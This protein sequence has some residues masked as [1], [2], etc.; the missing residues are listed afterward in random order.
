MDFTQNDIS[1]KPVPGAGHAPDA[2]VTSSK[3]NPIPIAADPDGNR[4]IVQSDPTDLFSAKKDPNANLQPETFDYQKNN[5][6]E[7]VGTKNYKSLGYDPDLG[8]VNELKYHQ[9]QTALDVVGD[10]IKGFGYGIGHGFADL[11]MGWK[12]TASLLTGGG[13][14]GAFKEDEIA[15][16]Q[17]KQQQREN[18]Y[19]IY[20][21]PTDHS[22]VS[23]DGIAKGIQ[24]AGGIVG[25][26]AEIV[27]EQVALS[28]ITAATLG[29]AAPLQ[30]IAAGKDA[31]VLGELVVES[32][33]LVNTLDKTAN[34]RNAYGAFKESQQYG[35][36]VEQAKSALG[37]GSAAI[38][39]GADAVGDIFSSIGRGAIPGGNTLAAIPDIAR[40]AKAGD[41][42]AAVGRG[43][44]AFYNDVRD[45]NLAVSMGQGSAAST[46]QE[47]LKVQTDNYKQDN[48]I[49]PTGTDL[50]QIQDKAYQAAKTSGAFNALAAFYLNKLA[51]G[52]MLTGSKVAQEAILSNASGEF[53]N[54]IRTTSAKEFAATGEKLAMKDITWDTF[55]ARAM[56]AIDPRRLAEHAPSMLGHGLGFGLINSSQ[57]AINDAVSAYY[58]AKYSNKAISATD[59]IQQGIDKQFTKEGARSFISGVI[60]GAIVSPLME[61]GTGA[62]VRTVQK[63]GGKVSEPIAPAPLPEN[64]TAEQ[65]TAYTKDQQRYKAQ[66]T[67]YQQRTDPTPGKKATDDEKA[68]YAAAQEHI[69]N[70]TV[71]DDQKVADKKQHIEDYTD[72]QLRK[73]NAAQQ[74]VDQVNAMWKNPLPGIGDV[75]LQA[76]WSDKITGGLSANDKKGTEDAQSDATINLLISAAQNGMIKPYLNHLDDK[77]SQLSPQEQWDAIYANVPPS[78]KPQFTEQGHAELMQKVQ[79]FKNR[80][81]DVGKVWSNLLKQFPP[82]INP[83]S[84]PLGSEQREAAQKLYDQHQRALG[85]IAYYKASVIDKAERQNKI[86]NGDSVSGG[87][88][89]HLHNMPFFNV[90]SFASVPDMTEQLELIK[91]LTAS[92]K[93][94]GNNKAYEYAAKM[95]K[96]LRTYRDMVQEYI[97]GYNR[98]LADDKL[99]DEDRTQQTKDHNDNYHDIL[100]PLL[101]ELINNKLLDLDPTGRNQIK[102]RDVL[103]KV[104]KGYMDYHL[105]TAEHDNMLSTVNKVLDPN[106]K[107]DYFR[108]FI[109]AENNTMMWEAYKAAKDKPTPPPTGPIDITPKPTDQPVPTDVVPEPPKPE[110]PKPTTFDL[111]TLKSE[112]LVHVDNMFGLHDANEGEHTDNTH[113]AELERYMQTPEGKDLNAKMQAVHA[114]VDN[115]GIDQDQKQEM[116]HNEMTH[117]I[118][119]HFDHTQEMQS[120]PNIVG[121]PHVISNTDKDFRIVTNGKQGDTVYPTSGMANRALQTYLDK[122]HPPV[123][124]GDQT[125]R[126]GQHLYDDNGK[127]HLLYQSKGKPYIDKQPATPE[128]LEQYHIDKPTV[129]EP[130]TSAKTYQKIT[131][132]YNEIEIYA[133]KR[134][135]ESAEQADARLSD[136]L[137]TTPDIS[138]NLTVTLSSGPKA[139]KFRTVG[140]DDKI[141]P[142]VDQHNEPITAMV[143]LNGT[144]IGFSNT[145]LYRIKDDK[146]KPI[147]TQNLTEAD[148]KKVYDTHNGNVTDSLRQFKENNLKARTILADMQQF[149]KGKIGPITVPIS[150]FANI[151]PSAGSYDFLNGPDAVNRPLV[152]GLIDNGNKVLKVKNIRTAENIYG[153][154]NAPDAEVSEWQGIGTIVATIQQPNG[155][156]RVAQLQSPRFK[157]IELAA[158][159]TQLSNHFQQLIDI[160]KRDGNS[161]EFKKL[162]KETNKL[163]DSIFYAGTPHTGRMILSTQVG[164]VKQGKPNEQVAIQ[165]VIFFRDTPPLK[166]MSE[167]S[168][169]TLNDL[170]NSKDWTPES[171]AKGIQD[172]INRY[173][174]DKVKW[175]EASVIVT[176]DSMRKDF[177]ENISEEQLMQ[178][179][180]GVSVNITKDHYLSY[181]PKAS[182]VPQEIVP[183]SDVEPEIKPMIDLRPGQPVTDIEAKRA[184]IEKRKEEVERISKLPFV[185]RIPALIKAG[186]I[187]SNITYNLGNRFPIIIN[188][189][190]VKVAFY[191]SSEG[192]GGKQK[193]AWTPMFGF[194]EDGGNPWLIKGDIDTQVN[195]N[196]SSSAIKEY[197]DILNKTLNWDHNLDKGQVN[198]HP[199]FKVLTLA[200]SKEDFNKELYGIG[201]LGIVNRETNV[202]GYINSKL[203]EINAKYDA[204]LKALEQ[205]PGINPTI[206]PKPDKTLLD[207]INEGDISAGFDHLLDMDDYADKVGDKVIDGSPLNE[208]QAIDNDQFR[209]ELKQWIPEGLIDV[210]EMDEVLGRM[211]EQGTTIGQ[212]VTHINNL[213]NPQGSIHL[214]RNAPKTTGYHEAGHGILRLLVPEKGV[215]QLLRESKRQNPITQERIDNFLKERPRFIGADKKVIEDRVA[216]EHIMDTFENW[217]KDHK[218]T[219]SQG[220]KNFFARLWDWIKAVWNRIKGDRLEAFFYDINRGAYKEAKLADNRF[221]NA[222]MT[223]PAAKVIEIGTQVIQDATGKDIAIPRTLDADTSNQITSAIAALY[224]QHVQ[225]EPFSPREVVLNRIL[226]MY[227]GML[228]PKQEKYIDKVNEILNPVQKEQFMK[229]L[230]NRYQ[231]FNR[232]DSRQSVIDSVNENLRLL[233][234]QD[235][236]TQEHYEELINADIREQKGYDVAADQIGG[237]ENM[238]KAVKLHISSTTFPYVDEFGNTELSDGIPLVQG[239]NAGM[240]YNGLLQTLEGCTSDTAL[241]KRLQAYRGSKSNPDTTAYINRLLLE[242]G[243]SD[244]GTGTWTVTKNQGLFQSVLNTFRQYA[245]NPLFAEVSPSQG[246]SR[247]IPANQQ[248]AAKTQFSI[249]AQAHNAVYMPGLNNLKTKVQ[250]SDYAKGV[251]TKTLYPIKE[252]IATKKAQGTQI[253]DDVLEDFSQH[254]SN[255]IKDLIGMSLSPDLI[256]YSI[257]SGKDGEVLTDNQKQLINAYRGKPA[258]T[259]EQIDGVR[260][261][262]LAGDNIFTTGEDES[263]AANRLMAWFRA[264]IPFDQSAWSMS[265]VDPEGKTRWG[266]QKP[267]YNREAVQKLNDSDQ[268]AKL[269]NTPDRQSSYLLSDPNFLAL[270]DKQLLKVYDLSGI[271]Q[272]YHAMVDGEEGVEVFA[273]RNLETNQT[274]G[275]SFKNLSQRD[276]T[277]FAITSYGSPTKVQNGPDKDDYFYTTSVSVG[278]IAESST[279]NGVNLPVIHAVETNKAGEVNLSQQAV[280]IEVQRVLNDIA[281][282]DRTQNEIATLPETEQAIDYHNG[283]LRGIRLVD[284]RDM[285][286]PLADSIEQGIQ[287][288]ADYEPNIPAIEKQI[289]SYWK[290]KLNDFRDYLIDQKLIRKQGNDLVNNLLPDFISKGFVTKKGVSVEGKNDK[291]NLVAGNIRHNLAQVYMNNTLN[292]H[293]IRQV[294]YGDNSIAFK[295]TI[296]SVRKMKGVNGAGESMGFSVTAPDLGINHPLPV[297]HHALIPTSDYTAPTGEVKDEADGLMY[298]TAKGL[299]YALFGFGELTRTQADILDAI[300]KGSPKAEQMFVEAGG[301]K[302]HIEAFNSKKVVY[303]DGQTHLKC[304]AM[305]LTKQFTSVKVG[306]KWQ[307]RLGRENLHHIR[308]SMEAFEKDMDLKGTPTIA[309]TSTE[310]SSKGLKRTVAPSVQNIHSDYFHEL[311][312]DNMRQQVKLMSNK[313]QI[314]DPNGLKFNVLTEQDPTAHSHWLNKPIGDVMKDYLKDTAQRGT[315]SY[316]TI[317]NSMFRTKSGKPIHIDDKLHPSDIIPDFG[318]VTDQMRSIQEATGADSQTLELLT[319]R[320]GEQVYNWNLSPVVAK[321]TQMYLSYM[322]SGPLKEKVPGMD[323]VLASGYGIQVVREIHTLDDNGQPKTWTVHTAAMQ[324]SNGSEEY[325][326]IHRHDN[327]TNK[328][329]LNLPDPTKNKVYV[330]DNLKDVY[331]KFDKEGKLLGYF[332][333][334]I[335]PAHFTDEVHGHVVSTLKEAV[336]SRIPWDDKHQAVVLEYVDITPAYMGSTVFMPGMVNFRS[337]SDDD[338]DTVKVQTMDTYL[339]SGRRVS[340]GTATTEQGM[341]HEFTNW[342]LSGKNNPMCKRVYTDKLNADSAYKKAQTDLRAVGDIVKTIKTKLETREQIEEN[343]ALQHSIS[344]LVDVIFGETEEVDDFV[345]TMEDAYKK[346]S[347]WDKI[348]QYR[349]VLDGKQW[350]EEFKRLKTLTK[351]ISSMYLT[352]TLREL[353]MPSTI[354]EFMSAG[355]EDINNGVLNNRI[356]NQKVALLSNEHIS[357]GGKDAIINQATD[358]SPVKD[359]LDEKNSNSLIAILRDKG[360]KDDAPIMKQLLGKNHDITTIDGAAQM[361]DMAA[362]GKNDVG[363][364]II[365][366]MTGGLL[367]QYD[368]HGEG[369]MFDGKPHNSFGDTHTSAG[370]RKLSDTSALANTMTDNL[371]DGGTAA[372][373][374]LTIDS[375]G[376]IGAMIMQGIPL[377]SAMWYMVQ[378]AVQDYFRELKDMDSTIRTAEE[379]TRS[380]A[381]LLDDMIEKVGKQA[382]AQNPGMEAAKVFGLDLTRD[383]L[384]DNVVQDGKDARIQYATLRDIATIKRETEAMGSINRIMSLSKGFPATWEDFDG[385]EDALNKLGIEWSEQAGRYIPI[386]DEAFAKS[387][388]P[389]DVR[390]VLTS[391]HDIYANYLK[392]LG[393]Q[394]QLS[395]KV[396]LERTDMFKRVHSIITGNLDIDPRYRDD[397]NKMAKNDFI[398]YL[399]IL[400]NIHDLKSSGGYT[401]TLS[402]GLIYQAAQKPGEENIT[403][404]VGRLRKT[405]KGKN[406]NMLLSKFLRVMVP[407][408]EGNRHDIYQILS[409]TWAKLS[410]QQ[411]QKL[412]DSFYSLYTNAYKDKNGKPIQTRNDALSLF[413]YLLV[414]D[415]GQFKSGS[416]VKI[417]PVFLFKNLSDATGRVLDLL[418]N[419][420]YRH[421]TAIDVLGTG[422]EQVLNSFAKSYS[423]HIGNALHVKDINSRV[424]TPSTIPDDTKG[425]D[426]DKV[427]QHLTEDRP[428]PVT[429]D[430]KR[431]IISLDLF[432]GI[433]KKGIV[434]TPTARGISV[435]VGTKKGKFTATEKAMLDKNIRYIKAAG[436]SV[437]TSDKGHHIQMPFSVKVNGDRYELIGVGKQAGTTDP[438]MLLDKDETVP[439]G[440]TGRYQKAPW[441]GSEGQWRGALYGLFGDPV[442]NIVKPSTETVENPPYSPSSPDQKQITT[443]VET[444]PTI[445]VADTSIQ[446]LADTGTFIT[447]DKN[448]NLATYDDK[449]T[450][451]AAPSLS[452]MLDSGAEPDMEMYADDEESAP[453][454]MRSQPSIVS[455]RS[456]QQPDLFSQSTG[457]QPVTTTTQK[458]LPGVELVKTKLDIPTTNSFIDLIQPQIQKQAYKENKGRNA[459]KMFSFGLNWGRRV[460]DRFSARHSEN[461]RYAVKNNSFAGQSDMYRYF[462][463][464]QNGNPISDI[465]QL[466]PIID[467]IQSKLGIDMSAYDTVL[468]NIYEPGTFISQHRDTTES[469]SAEKYPVIVLNLGATG[470]ILLQEISGK[471]TKLSLG[472]GEIYAFG[473]DGDNRLVSH[474]TVDEI[475]QNPAGMKLLKVGDSSVNNYR[476]TLTFRRAQDL[477]PDMPKTPDKTMTSPKPVV[478]SPIDWKGEIDKLSKGKPEGWID[479]ARGVYTRMRGKATN[480]EILEAIKNCI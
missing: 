272:V 85:F 128:L 61:A 302:R 392:Q 42:L 290:G 446:H 146:G 129:T 333:E 91:T 317:V 47:Q 211:K 219:A 27:A 455:S 468:G 407:G 423:S 283:K 173:L 57:S 390:D 428:K 131:K 421:Q 37:V 264:N 345:D 4:T 430:T 95:G 12:N 252:H 388:I 204:D 349:R 195:L 463:R 296:D 308:E 396:F 183:A 99:S 80:A 94:P 305:G 26:G 241:I 190:G 161:A 188:I 101:K 38:A 479:K 322:G 28:L 398:S 399:S 475:G 253:D 408:E 341:F 237:F 185:E 271:K 368:I 238:P 425:V 156:I 331:P 169:I 206:A 473:I 22:M 132:I 268:I 40:G 43:F 35:T 31:L 339:S 279:Y 41:M 432:K 261:S 192:T 265:Y 418:G 209:E 294:I 443:D 297:F 73:Q 36:L 104:T 384:I 49:D 157:D 471:E 92:E 332:S 100:Q 424:P 367:Q 397:M 11:A 115:Q 410:N 205:Q 119:D 21:D 414:K 433:R 89:E 460:D 52:N 304:T 321:T 403:D 474:R 165:G 105:L 335:R 65:Q 347:K 334:A 51:F 154:K 147:D 124:I 9:A 287:D 323:L 409:N 63:S 405:L 125:Y 295:D 194:G 144:P 464:D 242:S 437:D 153:D 352:Q 465:K 84:Y 142:N 199:Y 348:D 17:Q 200:A 236:L 466:Q 50:K 300:D 186:I 362:E 69:A 310:N 171:F 184:D 269:Q 116:L 83:N 478:P 239:V 231:V 136:T 415:G 172:D 309:F 130:V 197:A 66:K 457:N 440:I 435:T 2:I 109:A 383:H 215:A 159:V 299:R 450:P 456:M 244:D 15:E 438:S 255:Q 412:Q 143:N 356:F 86:L 198:Q 121:N 226:D 436:F 167:R 364:A 174:T 58:T 298:M 353:R 45:V 284:T 44:G 30:E 257:A 469:K 122:E 439:Q 225:S 442:E 311:P 434:E 75:I 458:V 293:A 454:V 319:T 34:L 259:V 220:M 385:L 343:V 5:A 16:A 145:G 227:K 223:E 280:D 263:G 18:S 355:G 162:Q 67:Y 123:T 256:A 71:P 98:I 108:S 48:G 82:T 278:P 149:M 179:Q 400:A 246:T 324:D 420:D 249:C 135:G 243:F 307:P 371:K 207:S 163:H 401:G 337:G 251:L 78:Q 152:Q 282:I 445:P 386:S 10:T 402:Q 196:Y 74:Y 431:G 13:F 270:S 254:I 318:K 189:A 372:K 1:A 326:D 180:S 151:I 203:S 176:P 277:A 111:P 178:M 395:K 444:K 39:Q 158:L 427:K 351:D 316:R 96:T 417:V 262:M 312:A 377:P 426:W 275:A 8:D 32:T 230:V 245:T 342:N 354:A 126:Y 148:W 328:T 54:L 20:T 77:L 201:D 120:Y 467:Y 107:Y 340:Y 170:T 406:T 350:M 346:L 90:Q 53:S 477:T 217:K 134:P 106:G 382:I 6:D 216:E 29:A 289:R 64:P 313:L 103:D 366:V 247:V 303:A 250:K 378:P 359:L 470:P 33:K 210:Q 267:T 76:Q 224:I 19:H 370:I 102:D 452:S 59:A 286:G 202:S 112:M 137:R 365:S 214:F 301:L 222:A 181:E 325:R 306:G 155:N 338:G 118:N 291:M 419:Q 164:I 379:R 133:L 228:Y 344:R 404:I 429:I 234:L 273:N 416:F 212:F 229:D 363:A 276:N 208:Q 68:T 150:H 461:N 314:T 285:L 394:R 315:N 447:T 480:N 97:D 358:T 391:K 374:G 360:V 387:G 266:F 87:I 138:N 93:V 72:Y 235:N 191:R 274:K 462:T 127:G 393:Q 376:V 381:G 3:V 240:V 193:G 451:V 70:K 221:T 288:S 62:I 117:L 375:V 88:Q 413:H 329:Y 453:N 168:H 281:K 411:Q 422:Y 25:A 114:V 369:I 213:G 357:G 139:G 175:G 46:Y 449:G 441:F 327:A 472:N 476:I 232:P 292:S 389:I 177:P 330:L 140:E 113:S 141:N 459:N 320:D 233:G 218:T 79:D 160:Y 24:E 380:K 14:G 60:T 182:T 7:F 166:G 56:R 23:W 110:E 187:A 260:D 361:R 248:D 336:G 258:M 81:A 373:L 55:R 448:G